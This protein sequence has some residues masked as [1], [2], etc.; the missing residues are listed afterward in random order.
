VPS[1]DAHT[2]DIQIANATGEMK[3]VE[4]ESLPDDGFT[5]SKIVELIVLK[6]GRDVRAAL[7]ARRCIR[8]LAHEYVA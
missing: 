7:P 2:H 8:L 4:P 1:D 6:R 3:G 5:A